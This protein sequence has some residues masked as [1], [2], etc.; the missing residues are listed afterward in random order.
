MTDAE[1]L[2]LRGPDPQ[3]V[4]TEVHRDM[5]HLFGRWDEDESARIQRKVDSGRRVDLELWQGIDFL[6]G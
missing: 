2:T 3:L 4:A 6:T 5:D 1:E